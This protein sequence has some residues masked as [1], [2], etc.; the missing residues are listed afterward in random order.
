[1][2]KREAEKLKIGDFVFAPDIGI[3]ANDQRRIEAIFRD[4]KLEGNTPLFWLEGEERG[5]YITYLHLRFQQEVIRK[6]DEP[7][8]DD[9]N[10]A[11][12]DTGVSVGD[13]Q[14]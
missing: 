4:P 1:M 13:K 14:E 11:A 12:P 2:R 8:F 7:F 10:Y 9:P 6:T 5:R 3:Y